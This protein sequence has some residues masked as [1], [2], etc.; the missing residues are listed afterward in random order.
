MEKIMTPKFAEILGLLCSEGSHILSYSSYWEK[1]RDKLRF[2]NNKKSERIEFYNKDQKLLLHYQNLLLGEFEHNTKIT[3]HG[4]INI[5]KKE[6]IKR[7]T[8][9]TPLG[10]LKWRVPKL[11]ING[12]NNLKIS[13]LRGFFDGDGTASGLVRIFSTNPIGIKQI[14]QLLLELGFRHSIQGPIIRKY[15]KP[16]YAIQLS[17]KDQVRFLDTIKPISK[18]PKLNLKEK[19][20]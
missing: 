2:R 12:D 13:F 7:I 16:H 15:R 11:V 18:L 9:Q 10:H 6:I 14:S 20:L 8:K 17:R 4:K 19:N 1:D 3:K 5:G